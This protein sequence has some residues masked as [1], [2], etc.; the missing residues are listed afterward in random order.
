MN[1]SDFEEGKLK[2]MADFDEMEAK[3]GSSGSGMGEKFASGFGSKAK[4]MGGIFTSIGNEM[5]S[6][7]LPFGNVM[8]KMGTQISSNTTK[9]GGF[10]S[11]LESIGKISV[12]AGIAGGLAVAGEGIKLWD[13]YEKALVSFDTVAKNTG[14]TIAASNKQLGAAS[15]AAAKL[16]FDNTDVAQSM[17]NLTMATG[18]TKKAFADMGLVEDLARYKNVSLAA[19]ADALDHVYGGSTRTLLSWGI[20]LNVS[21][22][23]LH[24]LVTEQQ[25][26]AKAQLQLTAVQQKMSDGQLVGVAASAAL[27]SAQLAVKDANINYATSVGTINKILETLR[28]RTKG[29]ADAFSKTFAGQVAESRAELHNFG[30]TIGHDVVDVIQR[31]EVE[32]S[33]VINWFEKYKVVAIALGAVLAGPIVLGVL[34]FLGETVLNLGQTFLTVGNRFNTFGLQSKEAT[35]GTDALQVSIDTM[36][37]S[38]VKASVSLTDI[39]ASE[40]AVARAAQAAADANV[41]LATSYGEVA[42]QADLAA[43]GMLDVGTAARVAAPEVEASEAGMTMGL[44]LVLAG[45]AAVVLG[46]GEVSKAAD[47]ARIAQGNAVVNTTQSYE[48]TIGQGGP[49]V[50]K[51]AQAQIN[52]EINNRN[53]LGSTG[54]EDEY[55]GRKWHGTPQAFAKGYSQEHN[56]SFLKGEQKEYYPTDTLAQVKAMFDNYTKVATHSGLWNADTRQIQGQEAELAHY[57][58]DPAALKAAEKR[59]KEATPVNPEDAANAAMTAA[60]AALAADAK[61]KP[62]SSTSSDA[63][64]KQNP[65]IT[66]SQQMLQTMQQA[67]QTGTIQSLRPQTEFGGTTGGPQLTQGNY[68]TQVGK[69]TSGSF[70]KMIDEVH[71]LFSKGLDKQGQQILAT[72]N[73]ELKYYG[74]LEAN[75]TQVNLNSELAMQTTQYTDQTAIIQDMAAQVVQKITDNATV[76]SARA[77]QSADLIADKAAITADTLGERG[78]YGLNLV[79]QE[80]KVHLDVI[81][82]KWTSAADAQSVVVAKTAKAGDAAVSAAKVH[83]DTVQKHTDLSVGLIQKIAN[84][85]QA[86]GTSLAQTLAGTH[87]TGAQ[88][89]QASLVA[90]ADRAYDQ[91]QNIANKHNA[92]A[93][94]TLSAIQNSGKTAEAKQNALIS[95]EQQK[96]NT[97]FAGS[98]VHI[99]IT[100]INPTDSTAIAAK[101]GWTMRTKVPS[102]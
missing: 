10:K 53:A 71:T 22:G 57:R 89:H 75:L 66:A 6:M 96:A 80:M 86:G 69:S 76:A 38:I 31:L 24:S 62:A 91:A 99:E 83:M 87:L 21:S 34:L 95:I 48:N 40:G 63:G 14:S 11:S 60:A 18:G 13:G 100:G 33:K 2:T 16:G 93:Q 98:G 39:M 101:V 58:K 65:L 94:A 72:Y 55:M 9:L 52:L 27:A 26:A 74:Q 23:R 79:T 50:L 84:A 90:K 25:A 78:L 37:A 97:E 81:T 1:R 85:A 88:A 56:T 59:Y 46:W 42:A 4:G 15:S 73:A 64:F 41:V 36:T 68:L 8:T 32:I 43:T 70:N 12:F 19:A 44:S 17:A 3:G 67:L 47:A 45:L 28:D 29:A 82:L 61:K 5:N 7:G 20:N 35:S 102:K 30:V 77:T 51:N 54:T 92:T 49:N